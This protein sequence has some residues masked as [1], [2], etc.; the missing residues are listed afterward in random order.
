[1]DVSAMPCHSVMAIRSSSEKSWHHVVCSAGNERN[2]GKG[3]DVLYQEKNDCP[4]P[5]YAK[6]LRSIT[7][8]RLHF[9]LRFIVSRLIFLS[10]AH[11]EILSSICLSVEKLQSTS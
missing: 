9:H 3:A 10:T 8:L 5:H 4:A 7:R 6:P 1:M 2:W 11:T